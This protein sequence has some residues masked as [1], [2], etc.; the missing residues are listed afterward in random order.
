MS[1]LF[2]DLV[3]FTAFSEGRDPEDV[4]E[5]LGPYFSIARQVIGAYGGTIEKFIGDAVMA[6]CGEL[7]LRARTTLNALSVPRS[8]SSPR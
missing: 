5:V 8:N 1:V 2:C 3:S 4:R 7:R 6:V